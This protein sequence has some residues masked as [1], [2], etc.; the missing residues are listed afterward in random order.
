LKSTSQVTLSHPFFTD[1][2]KLL[3]SHV[4]RKKHDCQDGFPEIPTK[5]GF[6]L[7]T[8]SSQV[9][10][11]LDLEENAVVQKEG[12]KRSNDLLLVH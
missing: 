3:F 5:D 9:L 10:Q 7:N 2:E 4:A 11:I 1:K 12:H 6:M 8:L